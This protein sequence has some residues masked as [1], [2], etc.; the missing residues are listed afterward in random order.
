M[1]STVSMRFKQTR[2]ICFFEIKMFCDN[3]VAIEDLSRMKI[4]QRA[5]SNSIHFFYISVLSFNPVVYHTWRSKGIPKTSMPR[6]VPFFI[7][8]CFDMLKNYFY[9]HIL[10]G[11]YVLHAAS[12][13]AKTT[14]NKFT[15]P[16][17]MTLFLG[18]GKFF[19]IF[20]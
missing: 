13:L 9:F 5:N 20:S 11:Q 17:K 14:F 1:F 6:W 7:F 3:P 16:L 18:G 2:V 19:G 12:K 10:V 4:F 8:L 15:P